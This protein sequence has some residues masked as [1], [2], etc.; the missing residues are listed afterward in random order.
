MRFRGRYPRR[1]RR[2]AR[3][4]R[5]LLNAP[6]LPSYGSYRFDGPVSLATARG[7]VAAGVESGVGHA[8]TA[9]FLSERLGVPIAEHRRAVQM[10]PGDRALVFRLL[11]RLEEGVVLGLE[12]LASRPYEFAL[13]TRLR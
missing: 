13:M 8:A 1:G 3:G 2:T 6:V 10:R 4:R 9:R 7:F 12:D 5:L 11:Q